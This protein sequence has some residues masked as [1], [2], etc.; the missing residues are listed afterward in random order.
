MKEFKN[1]FYL[2][3]D[4]I[5]NNEYFS[6]S[7]WGDGELMILEGKNIDIRN[8]GNGEFRYDSNLKQY[9]NLRNE[10]LESYQYKDNNY[11]I[12]VACSCCV[13]EEKH[14]YMKELSKQSENNLTWAN[15]FVNSN[16]MF[17]I[18]ELI[19]ELSNHDIFLV[20][21]KNSKVGKLPFNVKRVWYVG[22]DA[23]YE[24]YDLIG[25]I[26]LFINENNIEN[27]IFLF[28]AGPLANILCYRLWKN[29]KKNTYIDIGS[30]LEPYL[31]LKLTRGYHLGADTLNKT[32]IW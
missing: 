26:I 28:G 22:A 13:G 15:L 5:K 1:D 30:I 12:G 24:D 7:R 20:T 27:S 29:N 11:Y 6:F 4:K 21:N 32:C 25:E 8:K 18:N 31:N 16:Y 3:L 23:W 17:T 14:K 2:F 9:N 10:L 19:P